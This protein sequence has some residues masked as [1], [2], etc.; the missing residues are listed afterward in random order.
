MYNMT[1]SPYAWQEQDALVFA[2]PYKEEPAASAAVVATLE[3]VDW[4]PLLN[5]V[6]EGYSKWRKPSLLLFGADDPFISVKSAFDFLES[7]RTNMRIA[8][9]SAKVGGRAMG[10]Q[11]VVVSCLTP[12]AFG[13]VLLHTHGAGCA[14][15]G[16]VEGWRCF[17]QH[18]LCDMLHQERCRQGCAWS[19]CSMQA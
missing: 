9:A 12:Q 4:Q 15:G 6:D 7:K 17:L 18:D 11:D 1:G 16:R 2:R 3:G 19:S 5:K 14:S 8:T 10:E 13:W